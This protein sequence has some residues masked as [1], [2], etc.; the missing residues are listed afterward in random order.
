MDAS[1]KE[2]DNK[3]N[4]LP[5]DELAEG[6]KTSPLL[7]KVLK[8][9]LELDELRKS[10]I[11]L[12]K[13]IIT[14]RDTKLIF[15]NSTNVISGK[16][17]THKSR[18]MEHMIACILSSGDSTNLLELKYN[19]TMGEPFII[20]I[21]TERSTDILGV[22][23]QK[24]L[25]LAGFDISADISDKIFYTSFIEI[26]LPLRLDALNQLLNSIVNQHRNRQLF[27]FLDV[28]QDF[29][30]DFNNSALSTELMTIINKMRSEFGA[31]VILIIHE[32]QTINGTKAKGHIG[33]IAQEKSTTIISLQYEEESKNIIKL[34]F[35]KTSRTA[36]PPPI[37]LKYN[38]CSEQLEYASDSEIAELKQEKAP[39]TEVAKTILNL[40]KDGDRK[41]KKE[42]INN[43]IQKYEASERTIKDRLSKIESESMLEDFGYELIKTKEGVEVVYNVRKLSTC[44]V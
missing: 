15:P 26:D 39:L 37:R 5:I 28:F 3:T 36:I 11:T 21:D 33:S 13:P 30:K 32:V 17:G 14:M 20:W 23:I 25:L 9:N 42:I 1:R 29:V 22:S 12:S 24:T 10:E 4:I 44:A 7:N 38:E 6:R 35:R 8:S 27:I 43:L 18:F 40:L 16:I 19:K 34:D 2:K 41:Y 31:T